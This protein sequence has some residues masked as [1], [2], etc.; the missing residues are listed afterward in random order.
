M[1]LLTL[2]GSVFLYEGDEIGMVDTP[3]E[4]EQLKDPVSVRYFPVYG[5]DGARTPMQWSAAPG[6]GFTDPGVEPWLPFGDLSVNVEDE[7]R[8][9]ESF[10]SLTRDLVGLRDAL[11]DLRSGAYA[12]V[13]SPDD[14][15]AYQRGERTLI[16]LNLGPEPATVDRVTGTIRVATVRARD[17]EE[18]HGT[19]TLASGEG[20]VVLLDVLP[21]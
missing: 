7:R 2:R 14:V 6:A 13:D 9:P 3:L 19:L 11:P 15:L 17:D 5:R 8:D 20:A 10:L 21:G 16:A 12:P 1:M 4:Q 18:I